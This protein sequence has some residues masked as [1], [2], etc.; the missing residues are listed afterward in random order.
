MTSSVSWEMA[1]GHAG[2]AVRIAPGTNYGKVF[3]SMREIEVK[4]QGRSG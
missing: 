3:F 2:Q 1:E 4:F